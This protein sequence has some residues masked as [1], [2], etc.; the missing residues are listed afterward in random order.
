MLYW[1][2]IITN[3]IFLVAAVWLGIYIVSRSPRRLVP[4]LTGLTLW[5]IASLF[6]NMLLAFNPPPVPE[7]LPP[8]VPL[9][10]PFWPAGTTASGWSGWLQ[11]WFVIPAIVIWHHATVILRP[12]KSN[13]W[14]WIRILSGYL[15]AVVVLYAHLF[16]NLLFSSASGNPLYLNSLIPGP[17]YPV[18]LGFLLLFTGMSLV[19]LR[20]SMLS[21]PVLMQKKQLN[22]LAVATLIAGLTGPVALLAAAFEIPFPRVTLTLLLGIGVI[23]IGIGVARYSAI[24]EGRIIRRDFIYNAIA[25][26]LITC[27]YLLVTWVSVQI[28]N[29]PG[30]VYIFIVLLAIIT[31][32]LIDISRHTLDYFFYGKDRREI[33]FNLQRLTR[34]V[35]EHDLEDSLTLILESM[36][37]SVRATYGMIIAFDKFKILPIATYQWRRKQLPVSQG[38]LKFDDVQHIEPDR[39]PIPFEDVAL[40]IPLYS[41]TDQ[42][43]VIIFGRPINGIKFSSADVDL[44]LY[45]SDQ[46]ADAIQ[47]ARREE[48]YLSQLSQMAQTHAPGSTVQHQDISVNEVEDALRH[49]FD[50]AHLGD[51]PLVNLNLVHRQLP[52]DQVTYIDQGKAV[53]TVITGV[54]E[55]LR[56]A[57]EPSSNPPPREW[58]PYMILNLAYLEDCPNRDIMSQLY[59]SE[60]TFNRTRR[61]GIRSVRRMLEEMEAALR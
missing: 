41:D 9:V 54:V 38:D 24:S 44:L 53:H 5:S 29:V 4:W 21:A 18:V 15:V 58:Y 28:F 35:G 14:R 47:N 2:S 1:I 43:G 36:C 10:F 57:G 22:I 56:P 33:R 25:M 40:L 7:Y 6:L 23:L 39:F 20:R 45:P 32:S 61:S 48:V 37:V 13:L 49:L 31:H 19:N 11:G 59:I 12:G 30:E 17:I 52:S 16:T 55:K 46:I 50:Y 8:W 27:F 42:I 51:T 60:G 34:A 26:T 3:F